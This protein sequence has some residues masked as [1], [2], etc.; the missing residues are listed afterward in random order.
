MRPSSPN[1]RKLRQTDD[2][3]RSGKLG[4]GG[5]QDER[6]DLNSRE[7]VDLEVLEFALEFLDD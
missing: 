7:L 3:T 2:E 5:S 6:I 1:T 4:Y